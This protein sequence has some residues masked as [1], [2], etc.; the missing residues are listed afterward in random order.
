MK[1]FLLISL[2]VCGTA[3]ADAQWTGKVTKYPTNQDPILIYKKH[4]KGTGLIK[5]ILVPTSQGLTECIVTVGNG[6]GISCN[7]KQKSDK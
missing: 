5:L 2:L 6:N 1:T 4:G 3:S 7:W